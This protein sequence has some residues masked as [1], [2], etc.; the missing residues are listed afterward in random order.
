MRRRDFIAGLGGAAAWPVVARGQHPALPVV[1]YIDMRVRWTNDYVPFVKGLNEIGLIEQ[2]DLFIDHREADHVDQLS[3]IGAE[4]ARSNV[5]VICGPMDTIIAA[6]KVTST[7]PMVFIGGAD[8]V[9][10]GLVASFN[11]P[12]GQVTGL[13]LY[14]GNLPSKQLQIIRELIPKAS[15]FGL[16]V[17]PSFQSG[18]LQAT[19][20]TDAAHLL[21]LTTIVER[22]TTEDQFEPAFIRF[23]QEGA[24]AVLVISN[25][26]LG[27]FADRLATLA[28]RGGLPL[29]GQSRIY[30][31]AGGFASYGTSTSDVIRQ[32]GT[33]VGRVLKGEKPGDLPVLQPTKFD[34]VINLKTAQTLGL[35]IPP[36]VLARADEVIE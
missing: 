13:R 20:A 34:L 14:A 35:N 25:L 26:F 28:L 32:A 3:A 11:R 16:L 17:S 15:R 7:V 36:I 24:D 12:R 19:E 10:A 21:D 31:A 27:S 8:P 29:F 23:Q 4:L 5:A 9:A 6:K 1:G 2:R 33:Y 18:E 22:V 30:P